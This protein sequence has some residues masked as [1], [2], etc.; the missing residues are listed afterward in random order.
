[1][2]P[3]DQ[4][5]RFSDGIWKRGDLAVVPE[6]LDPD[7]SFRARWGRCVGAT[8]SSPPTFAR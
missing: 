5:R 4:V 1:M 3:A 2:S 6:V 8:A 7:L